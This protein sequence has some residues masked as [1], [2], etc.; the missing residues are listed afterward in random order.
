M[1][2]VVVGNFRVRCHGHD[3]AQLLEPWLLVRG[4]YHSIPRSFF[5]SPDRSGRY[6]SHDISCR[7]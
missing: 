3:V 7:K 4:S 1:E 5:R 6:L 2:L